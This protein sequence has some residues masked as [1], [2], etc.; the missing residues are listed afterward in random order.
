MENI[1]EEIHKSLNIFFGFKKFKGNQEAA[2]KS[3]I[4]GSNTFVIMPTGG[5][6]SLCYQLPAMLLDG[7]AIVISPLIA[8]MKNQVDSIRSYASNDDIAHFFNSSLSKEKKNQV[9]KTV[10]NG[11][12]K[13]LFVAP[14][15]MTK[16]E[17]I[18]F[19]K[20]CNISFYAVDEAHCISEWGHDFR[21]EYRKLKQTIRQI[22]PKPIIA[23]TATATQK[24]K[25]DIVK[26][27]G[28]EKNN[29]FISSF[30]RP[31]L[32]YEIQKNSDVNKAIIQFIKKNINKS[33]II[34]CL[35]RKKA[36][37]ISELLNLN[38][39]KS[40]PYHAGIEYKKRM[41]TQDAFLMEKIDVVVATIAFGMGI[42]KPDVRYV[43]HY[44]LPKS[45]EN[46]YQE[47]GRAGRDGGE[48][49]C[50][51]FYNYADVEKFQGFNSKK[52]GDEKEIANQLLAEIVEFVEENSCR[53]KKLLHYFG[54]N[55]QP[56]HCQKKCDNCRNPTIYH[57]AKNE[58][59][60]VLNAILETNNVFNTE[61]LISILKGTSTSKIYNYQTSEL[62]FFKKGIDTSSEMLKK[63][64]RQSILDNLTKKDIQSLGRLSITES[65]K[66]FLKQ[67]FD[68]KIQENQSLIVDQN[69]THNEII[70]VKL[71]S[72]LKKLRKDIANKKKVPPFIILQDP[73]MEEMAIQY[74][75]NNEELK[76]INGIG[77]GKVQKYGSQFIETIQNYVTANNI[78]KHQEYIV[79]S[80]A[81][82]NDLKIFI[83]QCADRKR[84]F[85]DIIADK[86]I[87]METLI[88]EIENIVKSGTKIDINYHIDH[89]LD[90]SQQE[91]IYDYFLT[92]AKDDSI[93]EAVAYFDN[94]YEED[95]LRLMK[96]KLFSDLAN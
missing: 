87:D 55:Y 71:L 64:I 27:L 22:N 67:P 50:I 20:K 84:S 92:E 59:G 12:T 73:S 46:Y 1:H 88:K 15:T 23:L 53:R 33:G 74:P 68:F 48:G 30:N 5:G 7:V 94:E 32:D 89:I 80:K 58:L 44:N 69:K 34:Y 36:E 21:P 9:K 86:N 29:L 49:K 90:D 60:I 75:V 19:L 83:I 47:T 45:I 85:D 61:Q 42:D 37:E 26:N 81:N 65:G 70:D 28:L 52:N 91:E 63:I 8:L 14:E 72:I 40:L 31:N 25:D 78:Q 24:V 93:S 13:L 66:L 76:N 17:N 41:E 38:N 57:N 39:I 3:I 18:E 82:K 43:I 11:F 56:S 6:K 54:E 10:I 95:E 2:I 77:E 96:I 62:S 51:L 35:E 4:L 16:S 79:K